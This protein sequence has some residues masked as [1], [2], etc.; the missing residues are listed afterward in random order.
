M[1]ELAV[2]FPEPCKVWLGK[3]QISVRPIE[4][5][6]FETFGKAA[7]ELLAVMSS[8]NMQR[9]YE[10]AAEATNV[11]AVLRHCTD[12]SVWRISRLPVASAVE[13]MFIVIKENNRFFDQALV[14]AASLQAGASSS[15]G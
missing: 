2:L 15:S 1:S 7:G 12:L 3:K 4:F 13:L 6:H 14:R 5:R 9:V 11:Q 8:G 10:W